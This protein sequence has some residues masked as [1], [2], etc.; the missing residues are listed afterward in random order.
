MTDT[1]GWYVEV[2]EFDTE[3]VVKA[4]GPVGSE[5]EAERVERGV[6]INMNTE[7][8]FTRVVGR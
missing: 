3:A 8:Y 2:V 4:I 1:R 7:K 6:L 5:R